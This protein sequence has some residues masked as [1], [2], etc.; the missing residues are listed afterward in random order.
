MTINFHSVIDGKLIN[1]SEKEGNSVQAKVE[2]Y[3]PGRT[4]QKALRTVSLIRSQ[5]IVILY[6]FF[7]DRG[8]YIK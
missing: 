5:G 4:S 1:Q 7:R 3:N 8:L 2:D 6:T